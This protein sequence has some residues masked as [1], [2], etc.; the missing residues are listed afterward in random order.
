MRAV[1]D[2]AHVCYEPVTPDVD[3]KPLALRTTLLLLMLRLE[4]F[5]VVVAGKK[6][7]LPERDDF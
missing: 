6:I 2:S 5:L 7:V 4:D 1:V 3:N